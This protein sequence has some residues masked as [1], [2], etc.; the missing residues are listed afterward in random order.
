[1]GSFEMHSQLK[2]QYLINLNGIKKIAEQ[3]GLSTLSPKEELLK[4]IAKAESVLRDY[5][6]KIFFIS[7]INLA[8]KELAAIKA[9]HFLRSESTKLDHIRNQEINIRHLKTKSEQEKASQIKQQ[10]KR[11]SDLQVKLQQTEY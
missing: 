3:L 6:N 10:Q 7:E 9:W 8:N 2:S 5:K 4:I 1:M 11:I